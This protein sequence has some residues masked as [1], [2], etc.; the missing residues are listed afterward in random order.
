MFDEDRAKNK[1]TFIKTK[2]QESKLLLPES[3]L[4]L[5]K[6]KQ[7]KSEIIEINMKNYMFT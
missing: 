5:R 2:K 1:L 4:L 7:L 6:R 3:S